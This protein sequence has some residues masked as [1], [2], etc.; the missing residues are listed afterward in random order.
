MHQFNNFDGLFLRL[1]AD[2][3]I[4]TGEKLEMAK[5]Y[6]ALYQAKISTAIQSS[7]ELKRHLDLLKL[8]QIEKEYYQGLLLAQK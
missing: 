2:K 7:D 3:E 1:R 6:F 8:I 5:T 4:P